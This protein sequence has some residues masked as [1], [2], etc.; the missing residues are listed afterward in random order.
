MCGQLLIDFWF[1]YKL[2]EGSECESLQQK[3]DEASPDGQESLF[4]QHLIGTLMKLMQTTSTLCVL[5][6]QVDT[7]RFQRCEMIL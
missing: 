5:P 1:T 3:E 2:E 4:L 7:Y 6:H